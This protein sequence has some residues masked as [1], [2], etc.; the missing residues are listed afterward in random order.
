MGGICGGLRKLGWP[1]GDLMRDVCEELRS[2]EW[3]GGWWESDGQT[4]E[5]QEFYIHSSMKS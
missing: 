2:F 4:T 5:D 3:L 1:W